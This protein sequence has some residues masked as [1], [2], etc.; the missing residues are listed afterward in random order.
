MNPTSTQPVFDLERT[1]LVLDDGPGAHTVPVGP[2]FWETID[3][4][5]DLD[6][7]RLVA[8]FPYTADWDTWEVHP[9]GDEI[10]F[11]L[12]GAVDV[13]L[14][15]PDGERVVELRGRSGCIV[16]RGIWHRGVVHAPGD[17]LHITPG[18]GTRH[19][20]A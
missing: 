12:S 7:G 4:R 13:I 16:P 20:P 9:A 1:Y 5:S 8:I 2:D 3:A 10:V 18:A 19:R 11:L 17:V 15:E 6:D 14:D